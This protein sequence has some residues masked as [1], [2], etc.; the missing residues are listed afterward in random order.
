MFLGCFYLLCLRLVGVFGLVFV[1]WFGVGWFVL[2]VLGLV[3]C[4][5]WLCFGDCVFG[6]RILRLFLFGCLNCCVGWLVVLFW[7]VI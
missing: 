5:G 1:C 7:W 6:F 3:F 4:G 2:V